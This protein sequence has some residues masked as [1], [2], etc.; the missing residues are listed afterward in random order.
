MCGCLC[1]GTPILLSLDPGVMELG[2]V[3]HENK[4]WSQ[5]DGNCWLLVD[6]CVGGQFIKLDKETVEITKRF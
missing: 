1:G 6:V 3:A 5:K 4:E 2:S